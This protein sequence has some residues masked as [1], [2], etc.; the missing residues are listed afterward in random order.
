MDINAP[1]DLTCRR[2][3]CVAKGEKKVLVYEFQTR[4]ADR[5]MQGSRLNVLH[6]IC[7]EKLQQMCDSHLQWAKKD[8]SP[9]HPRFEIYAK[10]LT[11]H[12]VC[13]GIAAA[14]GE[15]YW[16]VH[17]GQ[18][19]FHQVHILFDAATAEE[20]RDKYYFCAR[21]A[22]PQGSEPKRTEEAPRAAPEE[23]RPLKDF[24]IPI[25]RLEQQ[26][27]GSTDGATS[28]S[29]DNDNDDSSGTLKA[30]GGGS[31]SESTVGEESTDE[32]NVDEYTTH[33]EDYG[34]DNVEENDITHRFVYIRG[35]RY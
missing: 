31:S 29:R 6:E 10:D 2:P 1:L 35:M 24:S 7:Y 17:L 25:Q 11:G 22:R 18:H 13:D 16:P 9:D 5:V 8:I 28:R 27:F 12:A 32:D 20:A 19:P 4:D 30:R 14:R 23:A 34:D 33:E 21:V 26:V 3:G 15:H